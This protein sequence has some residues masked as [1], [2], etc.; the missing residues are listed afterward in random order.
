MQV[1][2]HAELQPGLWHDLSSVYNAL[3]GRRVFADPAF[4]RQ[5]TEFWRA[6][7]YP[8]WLVLGQVGDTPVGLI[9]LRATSIQYRGLWMRALVIVSY[10]VAD[11]N[12]ILCDDSISG[13]FFAKA[14]RELKKLGLPVLLN[15]LL[16]RD[17]QALAQSAHWSVS[18]S[19]IN[20]YYIGLPTELA[21]KKSLVRHYRTLMRLNAARV[22]HHEGAAA[23][24]HLREL[25][26]MHTQRWAGIG[27]RSG[28]A[29]EET[30]AFY[31]AILQSPFE[32]GNG[33]VVS[34]VEAE[35]RTVAMHLGF[36]DTKAMIWHTP[37][38]SLEF[39]RL[40][41]GEALLKAVLD[42]AGTRGLT[43]FDLGNGNEWYKKRLSTELRRYCNCWF[44]PR[45]WDRARFA[46]AGVLARSDILRYTR[47][48]VSK[49]QAAGPRKTLTLA[50]YT[51]LEVF[52]SRLCWYSLPGTGDGGAI[53]E[54]SYERYAQLWNESLEKPPYLPCEAAISRFKAGWRLF[55]LQTDA[56]R[57]FGWVA[58]GNELF[59]NE[60]RA[61]V[62]LPKDCYAILDCWTAPSARGLGLYRKLLS[63]IAATL[64]RNGETI[65]YVDAGN[66]P[67]IRGITGAGG[68][69]LGTSIRLGRWIWR[70]AGLS[71]FKF[72]HP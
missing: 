72:S 53:V 24:E 9:P 64:P 11:V 55:T 32:E 26:A 3:P 22:N 70:S 17:A 5:C 10:P 28:F 4:L 19:Q 35:G 57:A 52:V 49:A 58:S 2:I 45:L 48:A 38:F 12:P 62:R 46:F 31:E 13:E 15:N 36:Y 16:E 59:V 50:R 39:L 56:G 6:R 69:K 18:D 21:R 60:I 30:R 25:F 47:T 23:C 71:S 34:V 8:V 65:I 41:P 7:G 42:Y 44:M 33:A 61:K 20:P 27:V 29:E 14:T 68:K 40:W 51:V 63:G 43:E 66:E 67:S 1:S 54:I 37:C